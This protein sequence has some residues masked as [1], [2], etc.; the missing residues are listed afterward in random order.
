M[1]IVVAEL[2]DLPELS[3]LFD[4]Y[5]VFYQQESDVLGAEDFLR[6][7][8]ENQESY[9][10]LGIVEEEV[11][12]FTQLYP[13]FSS[14]SMQQAWLLNDL[15]VARETRRQGVAQALIAEALEFSRGTGSK[16]ILLETAQDNLKAQQLYEKIG[17]VREK[18]QYFFYSMASNDK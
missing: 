5:R 2:E 4:A 13:I 1:E 10:W 14:V 8:M 9:I 12:G 15:Y 16:G 7:R 11:V 6:Q 3:R 18:N 17:F